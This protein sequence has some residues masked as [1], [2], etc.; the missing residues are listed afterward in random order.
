[1]PLTWGQAGSERT[2]RYPKTHEFTLGPPAE[3]VRGL[4][5]TLGRPVNAVVEDCT[6]SLPDRGRRW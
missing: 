5:M 1:M 6:A 2:K 3:G 4:S